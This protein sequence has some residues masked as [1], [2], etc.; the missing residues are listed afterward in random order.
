[1]H[2]YDGLVVHQ[3]HDQEGIIE[4]VDKDGV[5]AL[6]FGSHSRQ[7]TM[8]LDDP[9][10]LYSQY[11]RAMMG[12]LL[13]NE[14]PD[15]ILMIGL[16]GGT[17]TKYLLHQFTDCKIK[18]IEYRNSVLKIARSHFQLPLDPRLN[19]KIGCGGEYISKQSKL[20]EEKHDLIMIDAFDH[21]GMALEVSSEVF[22]DGCRT[23]L[24]D[25][26]LLAINLWGTNKDLF[27]QVA[28]N[29]GQVFDWKILF[30]PVRKRGNIIG[31]AFREN[32]PLYS[33]KELRQKA[34]QLE[35]Q[36]QIE[37]PLFIKDFK[38]NNNTVLDKVIKP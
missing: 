15:D 34:K 2:K 10:Q 14:K 35:Q 25:D 23:L 8:L 5:R 18:V 6:H 16:G 13:F 31:F 36:Y 21:E 26:G 22:F 4:I 27:Q 11:A 19:I 38:R 32:T 7:S 28:W 12:L 20:T 17:I 30:L 37:F 24:K 33:M 9:N 29:M 1:M 3:S